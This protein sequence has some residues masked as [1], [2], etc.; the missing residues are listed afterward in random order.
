V[1]KGLFRHLN[2]GPSRALGVPGNSG[3]AQRNNSWQ[4]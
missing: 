3:T 4:A 1:F 2:L